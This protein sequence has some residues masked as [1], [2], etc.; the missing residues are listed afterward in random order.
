V[1]KDEQK[2]AERWMGDRRSLVQSGCCN[3]M[4]QTGGLKTRETWSHSSGGCKAKIKVLVNM[5]RCGPRTAI[6]SLAEELCLGPLCLPKASPPH[7]AGL[8]W[9]EGQV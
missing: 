8:G 2:F 9:R 4:A 6:F 3:Q 1:F 7:T 5:G